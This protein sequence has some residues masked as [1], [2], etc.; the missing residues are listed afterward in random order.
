MD[1]NDKDKIEERKKIFP[2]FNHEDKIIPNQPKSRV[3]I[4]IHNSIVYKRLQNFEDSENT[5]ISLKLKDS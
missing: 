2:E 1:P 5:L 3:S 4:M